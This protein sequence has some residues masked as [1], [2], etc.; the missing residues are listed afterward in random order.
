MR[1]SCIVGFSMNKTLPLIVA[2][3]L[4]AS[5]M[6]FA[7]ESPKP[8][9]LLILADDLR[10]DCIGAWGNP[11]IHT[12][13]LDRLAKQG[14]TFR[15]CFVMGSDRPAVCTPSRTMLMTGRNL[16]KIPLDEGRPDN[17][18]SVTVD[19]QILRAA[20]YDTF[21]LGKGGNTY[22]PGCR[23][24][25][26]CE[27]F[28]EVFSP[29]NKDY[30]PDKI[31]A[32]LREPERTQRPFYINFAISVPHD[33]LNPDPEDLAR[34]QGDESPPLPRN[35]AASHA[36][37]AGFNLRDTN[38]RGFGGG[39]AGIVL[40]NAP[41]DKRRAALASYYAVVT[42]YDKQVGRI[43]DELDRTGLSKNTIVMFASDNGLSLWDHGLI[44]KQS[45]YET[46]NRVPLIIRGPG[47]PT[48]QQRDT[49]V[50]LSDLLPTMLDLA[51]VAVPA[52]M[53]AKSFAGS[54]ADPARIHRRTLY[55]AYRRE[56]RTFRDEEYDLVLYNVCHSGVRYTQLFHIKKDPLETKN[57]AKDPA[58]AERIARM[59]AQA[60]Q[61]GEELGEGSTARRDGA[62]NVL[63]KNLS[64]WDIWDQRH[65]FRPGDVQNFPAK[66]SNRFSDEE[67]MER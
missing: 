35:A 32:Y 7:A 29:K 39:T 21:Y 57:L 4:G 48:G 44:H 5:H 62:R 24:A 67:W 8:N 54:I 55:T 2:A 61:A 20:G 30:C 11:H 34:Y 13:N 46:D 47:I 22:N 3:I 51:G 56:I 28:S 64:F 52:T 17:K 60:R 12:P 63:L 66:F 27:F 16:F 50:Y 58:Q 14:V 53:D 40:S 6:A 15:S 65:E 37:F 23:T 43:L 18:P 31:I 1:V 38:C 33:P 41:E 9:L 19:S 36:D 49:Y 45:L 59:I 25:D 10:P 26:R 42:G